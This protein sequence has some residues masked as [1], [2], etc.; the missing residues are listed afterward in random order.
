M[1]KKKQCLICGESK[2]VFRRGLCNTHYQ[3]FM[4]EF[5]QL[6]TEDQAAFE[7]DAIAAGTILERSKPGRKSKTENPFIALAAKYRERKPARDVARE[8]LD[9]SEEITKQEKIA[10]KKKSNT[11]N[12]KVDNGSN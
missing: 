3:Q 7:A 1:P 5:R 9:K 2:G 11:A 6:S 8:L 10:T 12:Q 4:S